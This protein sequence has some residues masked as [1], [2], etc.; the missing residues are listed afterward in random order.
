MKFLIV[1]IPLVWAASQNCGGTTISHCTECGTGTECKTCENGLTG[2]ACN[3]CDVAKL[4]VVFNSDPACM[5]CK[6]SSCDECQGTTECTKCIDGIASSEL[7]LCGKCTDTDKYLFW[8]KC[9]DCSKSPCGNAGKCDGTNVCTCNE[10]TNCCTENSG[11]IHRTDESDNHYCTRCSLPGCGDCP[12][13]TVLDCESCIDGSKPQGG[14]ES[15]C[16]SAAEK[17]LSQM[18]NT[19]SANTIIGSCGILIAL[20]LLW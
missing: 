6:Y 14:I 17:Y 20:L 4:R 7:P 11:A 15:K 8:G 1:L 16:V 13:E 19:D 12:S 10:K 5:D 3:Q 18:D 9:I 2:T